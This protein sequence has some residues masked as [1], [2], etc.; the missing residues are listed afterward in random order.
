M[1]MMVKYIRCGGACRQLF[2][3][4]RQVL[5][6]VQYV[7]DQL[8]FDAARIGKCSHHDIIPHFVAQFGRKLFD[9]LGVGQAGKGIE[10]PAF[11]QAALFSV[12]GEYAVFEGVVYRR[13]QV[14]FMGGRPA[15]EGFEFG[16]VCRAFD[17]EFADC[18]PHAV[19]EAAVG[20][21]AFFDCPA[22]APFNSMLHCMG[23]FS[24][25]HGRLYHVTGDLLP[26][27]G[28][29]FAYGRYFSNFAVFG[30]TCKGCAVGVYF[31]SG[32]FETDP[33]REQFQTGFGGALGITEKR[34]VADRTAELMSYFP[35]PGNRIE[36]FQCIAGFIKQPLRVLVEHIVAADIGKIQRIV[37]HSRNKRILIQIAIFPQVFKDNGNGLFD[38]GIHIEKGHGDIVHA[39]CVFIDK[40]NQSCNV[41]REASVF[42]VAVIVQLAEFEVHQLDLTDVFRNIQ[43]K[44]PFLRRQHGTQ[45]NSAL[46]FQTFVQDGEGIISIQFELFIYIHH[47]FRRLDFGQ[48]NALLAPEDADV[49]DLGVVV[50][51]AVNPTEGIGSIGGFVTSGNKCRDLFLRRGR[52]SVLGNQ[53]GNSRPVN[54]FGLVP[55]SRGKIFFSTGQ[56]GGSIPYH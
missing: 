32:G 20:V 54:R 52:H 6:F 13:R 29:P 18:R 12:G 21:P 39:Q 55:C 44:F 3:L 2:G 1:T 8:F 37:A 5:A 10:V 40:L 24:G 34:T 46:Q 11:Y 30:H 42:A 28:Q 7:D 36:R 51:D 16:A 50:F 15:E 45:R 31:A 26:S 53:S 23:G 33:Q 25:S 47:G 56:K 14:D 41:A 4:E 27:D 35:D 9:D 17:V 48:G 22:A 38:A 19:G 43:P 49:V